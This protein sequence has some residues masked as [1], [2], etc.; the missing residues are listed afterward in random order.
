MKLTIRFADQI[1]GALIILA[2]GI[3]IFAIFML[4]SSQRWFS[5]DYYYKT[6]FQSAAGLSQNMAIQYK[7]FTIGQ[8]KSIKL[9]DDDRVEVQ[10]T[11][12]D[13]YIERVTYGSLVEIVVSPIG[14]LLGNEFLFHPGLGKI[15]ISEGEVIPSVDTPEAKQLKESGL[16]NLPED[17]NS[18]S[19]II[20]RVDTLLETLNVV[21]ADLQDAIKGNDQTTLGH[22]LTGVDSSVVGIQNLTEKLPADIEEILNNIVA[23]LNPTITNINDLT[24][25]FADPD[26]TVMRILNSQGEDYPNI[27]SSLASIAGILKNLD[28]T[29]AS[30]PTQVPVLLIEVRSVLQQVND[31]LV[32]VANNPLLKGGVPER[33]ETRAGG[34]HSRDFD[35]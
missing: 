31:V 9:T 18:I 17:D 16:V 19:I 15:Q 20:D 23:L 26:G 22:I 29:T 25:Q 2:L 3:L 14:A 11:I 32:A 4:G 21:L 7:G 12:Y 13:T 5:R 30:L 8:V 34:V 35:F 27:A 24:T 33:Q 1:V 10:F 28:D 6:Y